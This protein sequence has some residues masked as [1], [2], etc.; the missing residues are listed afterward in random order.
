[1]FATTTN[2][3]TQTLLNQQ[4]QSVKHAWFSHFPLGYQSPLANVH[5]QEQSPTCYR[6]VILVQP[7][8]TIALLTLAH[9]VRLNITLGVATNKHE[10]MAQ[11]CTMWPATACTNKELDMWC[12]T[13]VPNNHIKLSCS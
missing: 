10:L 9:G 2:K 12:S 7:I 5:E 4:L 1:L 13:Y 8:L 11:Q 6:H 3:L